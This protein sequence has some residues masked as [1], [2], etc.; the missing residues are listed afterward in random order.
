MSLETVATA[1]R[2]D[3]AAGAKLDDT[4]PN[5]VFRP[6]APRAPTQDL[7][8]A[9]RDL[10]DTGLCLIADALSPDQLE[11]TRSALYRAAEEDLTYGSPERRR[12]ADF[13]ESNQR[14]WGL[15]NR[16][17]LFADL[18]EHPASVDILTHLLGPNFLLSSMSANIAGPGH[19]GMIMHSDQLFVPQPWPEVP[20]GANVFWCLDDFTEENGG[21]MVAPGSHLLN[22]PAVEG[23][24][25]ASLVPLVAKAGT[26]CVMEGRVWHKTGC[27]RTT[28][29]RRAGVFGWY[30]SP[31][32]R[33]QENWFLSLNPLVIQR[34]SETLLR[35]LGYRVD[36]IFFGHVNGYEPLPRTLDW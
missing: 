9:K 26:M 29:Q 12:G 2:Q 35:M 28:D 11:R 32:Y 36:G 23:K 1:T 33:T 24:D 6:L 14:I 18:A 10:Q 15:L 17:P 34:A 4:N 27:N 22:R 5:G 19:G 13:D 31:I 3:G 8:Q 21:T 20:Q 30:V 7:E 16:S 25:D